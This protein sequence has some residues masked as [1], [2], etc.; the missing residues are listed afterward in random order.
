MMKNYIQPLILL[1]LLTVG[2]NTFAERIPFTDG[3]AEF[4]F[5][6]EDAVT[7]DMQHTHCDITI[8]GHEANKIRVEADVATNG[9]VSSHLVWSEGSR[10]IRLETGKPSAIDDINIWLPYRAG[11]NLQGVNSDVD[12]EGIQG[13]VVIRLVNGD[14]R[15]NGTVAAVLVEYVNGDCEVVPAVTDSMDPISIMG[16]NGDIRLIIPKGFQGSATVSTIHG[17]VIC[18]LPESGDVDQKDAHWHHLNLAHM[19]QKTFPIN[20]GKRPITL[21][22]V[23]GDIHI[24]AE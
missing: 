13:D 16:H 14:I 23:K 17:N 11:I 24:D 12:V 18:D 10:T 3:S 22:T 5:P 7:F 19:V 15:L 9:I 8:M 6:N 4:A 20:G 21:N 1:G 2:G